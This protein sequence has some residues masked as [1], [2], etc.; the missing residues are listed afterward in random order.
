MLTK[1]LIALCATLVLATAA[2]AGPVKPYSDFE[3]VWFSI[4]Q[5]DE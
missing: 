2:S 3:K 5:G 4:P 1:T